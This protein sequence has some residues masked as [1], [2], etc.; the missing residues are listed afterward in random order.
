ME[1]TAPPL[2]CPVSGLLSIAGVCFL[3]YLV[4]AL[5]F[6]FLVA[7][8][9]GVDD[10]RLRGSGNIGATNVMRVLGLPWGALVLVLDAAK[11]AF[12]AWLG[13]VYLPWG[14][15]GGLLTGLMAVTG[16]NWPVFLRFKG[17]KGVAASLGVVVVLYPVLALF[18]T[19]VFASTVLI[20]R[21]VSLGSLVA[22]WTAFVASLFSFRYDLFDRIAIAVFCILITVRHKD[23]IRRL[24]SGTERKIGELSR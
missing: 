5:P 7:K 19:A 14:R 10:I 12:G 11:G 23:N 22:S 1:M 8:L 18:A 6:G 13:L 24:I 16:H 2:V 21:Y 9:R 20:S 4:G 15:M 17:G 3:S